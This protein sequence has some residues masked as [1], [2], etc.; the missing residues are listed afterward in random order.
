MLPTAIA[1][2]LISAAVVWF[3]GRRDEA[4]DPRL[5]LM[6]L[7]LLAVF[8]LLFFLPEWRVL[9]PADG[10]RSDAP[11]LISWLPWIWGTGV[12]LFSTR[13]F[14]ALVALH[15]WR[16]NSERIEVREAGEALVDIR[17]LEGISGPVAAGIF[18]PVVFVP[19]AWREWP[20]ETRDAVLAHEI[21]HH[22]RRDPLL[23][24]IGAV[25]CT[26][27]WFNPLVWW[28]ARRL[29]DQCEFACDEE[30]L[31]DGMGPERYA[32]VLCDLAASTRSPATTLAMAHESGLEARVKRMFSKVP[33]GSRAA[34]SALLV[35]TSLT[36]LGL[37]VIRRADPPPKPAIPVEEIQIRLSADPFPG[38]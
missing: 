7:G 24:A 6:A 9:P 26:L 21:K 15:R 22:R 18:K 17:L 33:K 1:F 34:L 19:A 4:R 13:L 35:L 23:R 14:A 5:T 32:N 28:M 36:A 10:T 2:S 8:P 16:K 30:V 37:A 20:Q 12:L 3:A 29:A 25:A 11:D 27:H 38:N 31:A